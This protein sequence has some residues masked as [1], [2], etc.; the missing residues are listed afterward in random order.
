[1]EQY[2]LIKAELINEI[3][4]EGEVLPSND[5]VEARRK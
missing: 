5:F 3:F 1:M 2:A 4:G